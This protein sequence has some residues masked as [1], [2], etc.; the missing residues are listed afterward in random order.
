MRKSLVLSSAALVASLF[1]APLMAQTMDD[2]VA[3]ARNQLGLLEYCQTE[4]HTDGA[5]VEA[6]T[7]MM[8]LLPAATDA[9][10]GDEAY[11]KGKEGKLSVGGVEQ[12]LA[13]AEAQGSSIADMCKQMADAVVAASAQMGG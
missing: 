10:K 9:T 11:A 3:A 5:A 8:A 7:K 1:A 4:G 12:D 2:A 13:A 6:Q